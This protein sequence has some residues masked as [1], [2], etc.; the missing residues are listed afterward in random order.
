MSQSD[1]YTIAD[2]LIREVG[3]HPLR[4]L[5]ATA[6]GE[7]HGVAAESIVK[8]G[9]WCIDN[10]YMTKQSHSDMNHVMWCGM[11]TADG[12]EVAA[13]LATTRPEP[14]PTP[15]PVFNFNAP[16]NAG[17]IGSGNTQNVTLTVSEAQVLALAEELRHDGHVAEADTVLAATE[18]GK[19]PGRLLEA[20]TTIGPALDS[21][22]KFATAVLG[23]LTSTQ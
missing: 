19:Q 5:N 20:F 11:L 18:N 12:E 6:L 7:R 14:T 10:G 4:D 16:V 15:A 23:I 22:G 2:D 8:V 1:K 3:Q 21:Y 13:G 9:H 17:I